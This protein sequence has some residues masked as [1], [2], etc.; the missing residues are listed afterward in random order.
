MNTYDLEASREFGFR[1]GASYEIP[2]YALRAQIIYDSEID[3]SAEGT[4]TI[5]GRGV[6]DVCSDVTMPQSISARVQTGIDEKTLIY[7]GV[8]WME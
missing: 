7:A 1:L 5:E 4:Q 8:R 3:L 6:S 2:E